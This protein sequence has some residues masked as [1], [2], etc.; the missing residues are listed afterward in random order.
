MAVF[1]ILSSRFLVALLALP[2]KIN[3]VG[4]SCDTAYLIMAGLIGISTALAISGGM[5]SVIVTDYAQSI[6]LSF[7]IFLITGLI[8]FKLGLRQVSDTM[9]QVIGERA[10]NPLAEGSYGLTW[11]LFF[12][13]SGILAPL[14]FPP[15]TTKLSSADKPNTTRHMALLAGLFQS[16]RGII[17]LLWGAAAM[18][19]LGAAAPNGV[20]P[21]FYARYATATFIRDISLPG[22]LGLCI[23][24]LLFAYFTTGNSY[25]VSWAA[26]IV[27]DIIQPIRSKPLEAK[28][29]I[30]LMRWVIAA[31]GCFLFF[32]GLVFDPKESI[33]SYIYLTG[34]IFTAA[35]VITFVGLYWHRANSSGA[36]LTVLF[37]MSVP[38]ADIL[39][40][41]VFGVGF[42]LKSHE[43]GLI[44]L[45]LS[46]AAFLV[47]GLLSKSGEAKWVD[48]GAIA[49]R[50]EAL[51]KV[52]PCVG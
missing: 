48:Y 44:A 40:K 39:C 13:L 33:L 16:G 21:D 25:S 28:A 38:L 20:D 15:S 34:A 1:P 2:P 46:F 3:L 4:Q 17:V 11:I 14:T 22:T 29:H 8:F 36:Y 5:V 32:W 30:R 52:K 23:T 31:I 10:F 9:Q 42:P 18:T 7:S 24:G 19:Y 37:C 27:N 6:I 26:I 12:I 51:A 50:E 35:G 47:C 45:L 43:S 41:N 49:R